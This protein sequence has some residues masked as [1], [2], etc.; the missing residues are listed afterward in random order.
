V[1]CYGV[2]VFKG[3]G[4]SFCDGTICEKKNCYCYDLIA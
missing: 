2:R 4:D 3:C 1:G